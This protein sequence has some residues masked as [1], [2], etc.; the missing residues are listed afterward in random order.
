MNWNFWNPQTQF[1]IPEDRRE[2]VKLATKNYRESQALL[3]EAGKLASRRSSE[4]WELI[5]EIFPQVD[6]SRSWT[7]N[8][9]TFAVTL[10]KG[11]DNG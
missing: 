1:V 4:L 9:D 11:K 2:E 8:H 7:I 10:N 3:Q 6:S 5:G